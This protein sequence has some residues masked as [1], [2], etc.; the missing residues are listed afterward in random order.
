MATIE[1]GNLFEDFR[2]ELLEALAEEGAT[3]VQEVACGR[4]ARHT[5]LSIFDSDFVEAHHAEFYLALCYPKDQDANERLARWLYKKYY[6][7]KGDVDVQCIPDL[8][9]PYA[10][11]LPSRSPAPVAQQQRGRAKKKANN[12]TRQ[13]IREVNN[14]D[15]NPTDEQ[16]R[17]V[18]AHQANNQREYEMINK[19]MGATNVPK[20]EGLR[21]CCT[22][23]NCDETRKFLETCQVED[24]ALRERFL[25]NYASRDGKKYRRPEKPCVVTRE[26]DGKELLFCVSRNQMDIVVG[27]NSVLSRYPDGRVIETRNNNIVGAKKGTEVR[28]TFCDCEDKFSSTCWVISPCP[29]CG[30]S[31]TVEN[32]TERWTFFNALQRGTIRDFWL[33]DK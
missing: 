21:V 19:K 25:S 11:S 23:K 6:Q 12:T 8:L 13:A 20:G 29:T 1:T 30:R 10:R 15:G 27:F 7:L 4:H 16:E 24:S 2:S 31:M 3:D 5:C 14:A 32:K 26:S 9:L 18:L 33:K 17:F 22:N 28:L